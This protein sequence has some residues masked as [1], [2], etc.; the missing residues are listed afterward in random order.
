MT[1]TETA[2]KA[3]EAEIEVRKKDLEKLEKIK[4]A[5]AAMTPVTAPEKPK[6]G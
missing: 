2:I 3:I 1:N 6:A 4:A 5:L